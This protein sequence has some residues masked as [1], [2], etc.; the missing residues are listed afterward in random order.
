[1]NAWRYLLYADLIADTAPTVSLFCATHATEEA[2]AAF[3]SSAKSN[4]Y[5]AE[6]KNLNIHD[7]FVKTLLSVFARAVSKHVEEIELAF[8][9]H[10]DHDRL[11]ARI[12]GGN[13]LEIHPLSL[14]L[15]SYNPD[16]ADT[17][18]GRALEVFA[19]EFADERAMLAAIKEQS[20]LRNNAIY[21]SSA[22]IPAISDEELRR[23]LKENAC[24]T[25]GLVWAAL[26][27]AQHGNQRVAFIVQ[28]LG[29]ALRI[30]ERAAAKK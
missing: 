26:D 30:A 6:A 15:I 29:A 22:G 13:G 12:D 18:W 23:G 28:A 14:S 19:S 27:M 17:S 1:M 5:A 3:I 11:Y 8:A 7:H 16:T 25:I 9:L 10:P 21:A 2:V 20:N 24:I 4:G